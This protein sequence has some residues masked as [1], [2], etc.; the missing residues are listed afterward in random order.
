MA[1]TE[2]NINDY[3]KEQN[4]V[5]PSVDT[6]VDGASKKQTSEFNINEF[7]NKED[8]TST[9]NN[10]KTTTKVERVNPYSSTS[11]RQKL[12]TAIDYGGTLEK[13]IWRKGITQLKYVH[14]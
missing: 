10:V 6:V 8:R 4:G 1:E 13:K 11:A 7:L 5:T 3:L 9:N 2:F 14:I 12:A